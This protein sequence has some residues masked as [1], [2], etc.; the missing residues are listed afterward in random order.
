MNSSL[1]HV[2][3]LVEN[4]ESVLEK[5]IF[6]PGQ[7]GEIE[8]FPS[9]GT[10]EVYIGQGHQTGRL[11]LVQ[12]IEKGPYQRA[13]EKRGVGFHH[14]ALDVLDIDEYLNTHIFGSGWLL[15]PKSLSFYKDHKQVFLS[16]PG[17]ATLIEVQERKDLPKND[18]FIKKVVFPFKQSRLR[19]GLNCQ[20]LEE[21]HEIQLEISHSFLGRELWS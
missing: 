20:R 17:V 14:I 16:R 8:N 15:H 9:E 21:G 1:N 10:K 2:A 5:K 3:I 19:T 11:L 4:I 6:P 7:I 13:L 18:S 12:A